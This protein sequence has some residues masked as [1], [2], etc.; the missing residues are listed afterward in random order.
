M[1]LRFGA[2]MGFILVPLWAS[3]LGALCI[4]WINMNFEAFLE[5]F[6]NYGG[7]IWFACGPGWGILLRLKGTIISDLFPDLF[8]L[9]WVHHRIWGENCGLWNFMPGEV[10]LYFW[11][12]FALPYW[13]HYPFPVFKGQYGSTRPLKFHDWY[14]VLNEFTVTATNK[15]KY[16][17]KIN[18]ISNYIHI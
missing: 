1:L 6:P 4:V 15:Y 16:T 7:L 10:P 18:T 3:I 9:R 2:T 13:S 14:F 17:N 12:Y 8:N 5:G 11:D